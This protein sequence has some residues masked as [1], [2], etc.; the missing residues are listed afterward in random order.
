MRLGYR[1]Q[2]KA[3]GRIDEMENER[4][5]RS[6]GATQFDDGQV[7]PPLDA[8]HRESVLELGTEPTP[9]VC[10]APRIRQHDAGQRDGVQDAR[11]EMACRM[12]D[13]TCSGHCLGRRIG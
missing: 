10:T 3:H 4:E 9:T 8:A 6:G 5:I 12:P 7:P 11:L 2:F 13:L 1:R